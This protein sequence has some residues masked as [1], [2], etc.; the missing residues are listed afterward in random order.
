MYLFSRC[1]HSSLAAEDRAVEV[2]A[3]LG[4]VNALIE[5]GECEVAQ[6]FLDHAVPNKIFV[7]LLFFSLCFCPLSNAVSLGCP[8]SSCR[9][10]AMHYL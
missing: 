7:K 6:A 5:L 9:L 8:W 1:L 3:L 10:E 4:L 2:S